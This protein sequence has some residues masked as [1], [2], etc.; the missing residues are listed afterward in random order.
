MTAT[1]VAELF[2]AIDAGD[3]AA[4][5]RLLATDAALAE[6]RDPDGVSAVMHAL[7]RGRRAMA[8]RLAAALPDLDIFE[9]A[10][11]ARSHRVRKLL[12][13]DPT[14]ARVPSPD[15]F[16]ALHFPAFFGGA[17]AADAAAPCSKRAPT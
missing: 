1:A 4:L 15:G 8:E 12:A 3:E 14:L 2:A 13:A 10:A 5:D 16:T 7:Y 11:L 17:G 9:A 6:A